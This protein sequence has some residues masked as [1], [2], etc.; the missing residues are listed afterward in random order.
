MGRKNLDPK[1]H[2]ETATQ[3]VD[4]LDDVDA[5]SLAKS[6]GQIRK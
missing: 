4:V 5:E 2:D 6:I 1:M 3:T